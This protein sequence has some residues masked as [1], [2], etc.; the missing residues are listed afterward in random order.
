M[1]ELALH[2]DQAIADLAQQTDGN[3]LIVNEGAAAPIGPKNPAQ[4]QAAVFAGDAVLGQHCAHGMIVDDFES[5]DRR[6]LFGA[7]AHQAGIGAGA[8]RQTQGIE[9]DGFAGTGLAG[10]GTQATGERNIQVVDQDD[11]A[12]RQA[13]QHTGTK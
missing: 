9:K 7:R 3:R 13:D 1:R 11:I 6:G 10:Q 8:Q 4:D 12:D 2:L 5:G